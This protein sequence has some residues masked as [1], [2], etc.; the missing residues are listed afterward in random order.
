LK[1]TG[2]KYEGS[3]QNDLK[4]G[5]GRYTYP[6]GDIYDGEWQ[7]GLRHGQG[8]YMYKEAGSL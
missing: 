1:V 2:A 5:S 6:N 8:K 7:N 4:H 3:Y